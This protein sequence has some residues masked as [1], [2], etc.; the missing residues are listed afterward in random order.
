MNEN[1]IKGKKILMFCPAFF[2]YEKKIAE[3]MISMGAQVDAYDERSIKSAFNRAVLKVFPILFAGQSEKYYNKIIESNKNKDYDFILIIRCDM[4]T[5]HILEKLKSIFPNAKFCLYLWDSLKNIKGVKDKFHYFDTI[6][7]FDT[8]DCKKVDCLRFRPLFYL[9]EY[10]LTPVDNAEYLYD[11]TFIGTAHTDRYEVISKVEEEAGKY[12]L[13]HFW[14]LYLQNKFIYF[15]YCITKK[16]FRKAPRGTFSF[17][18][19]SSTDIASVIK[20]SFTV[21]DI[22]ANSQTGLT[23]RTIEMLGMNKKLVTTNAN[24]KDYDFFNPN[25]I[26]IIDRKKIKLDM[27]FFKKGFVPLPEDVYKKYSIERWILDIFE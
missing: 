7:S 19:M 23:M 4:I 9:D 14:F 12:G 8:E 16:S 27:E 22:E 11:I 18:K 26:Q 25:N 6:H 2:G 15:V 1:A 21:L 24:I 3:K 20:N 17:S 10:Q 5:D 13:K